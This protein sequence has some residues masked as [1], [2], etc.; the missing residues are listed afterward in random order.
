MA[1][2]VLQSATLPAVTQIRA[3]DDY[4]PAGDWK[5]H[6]ASVQPAGPSRYLLHRHDV[7]ISLGAGPRSLQGQ[8]LVDADAAGQ[9]LW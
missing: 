4:N 5:L 7:V 6:A 2:F 1:R 3:S 8:L 9:S